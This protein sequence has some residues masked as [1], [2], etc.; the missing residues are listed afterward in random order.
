MKP[1]THWLKTASEQRKK[2]QARLGKSKS[3]WARHPHCG[4][5][6]AKERWMG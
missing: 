3:P 4:T 6:R 2:A 1:K 5:A